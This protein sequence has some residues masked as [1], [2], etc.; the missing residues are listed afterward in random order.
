LTEIDTS[1]EASQASSVV[2]HTQDT[3]RKEVE[4]GRPVDNAVDTSEALATAGKKLSCPG[5]NVGEGALGATT[6]PG[7]SEDGEGDIEAY[8]TPKE[9][10]DKDNG[11]EDIEGDRG[12]SDLKPEG[13]ITQSPPFYITEH[14]Q[15]IIETSS[16][17]VHEN[18]TLLNPQST[19]PMDP[20][21]KPS[22]PPPGRLSCKER[23]RLVVSLATRPAK[24]TQDLKA[25]LRTTNDLLDPFRE[26]DDCWLH[27]SPPPPRL[28]N[29]RL[30]ARHIISKRFIF[31][32][33]SPYAPY[34][35]QTHS[36]TIPYGIAHHLVYHSLTLQQQDGWINQNWQ[37]SHLCGNWTCLNPEHLTVESRGI[38]VSR[39]N[40]FS[41]R[42]G[43][44]HDPSCLK[45]RKVPLGSD[46]LVVQMED[47][48]WQVGSSG[49]RYGWAEMDY[50][51][52]G[53]I[54]EDEDLGLDNIDMNFDGEPEG[55]GEEDGSY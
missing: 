6:G 32:C 20:I 31:T 9:Y 54:V 27:P 29:G 30:V 33:P 52:D 13:T 42:V 21:P 38:N 55:A 43:C 14:I 48:G 36:L 15:P 25:W 28:M 41:H 37:N 1:P 26:D 12:G 44:F 19:Q 18:H 16:S 49:E 4:H 2:R 40:C 45:D 34:E 35:L 5:Y 50:G 10:F 8:A 24:L 39:N 46:G 3:N 11:E 17:P 47:G 7:S 51:E 53:G 22:V 23:K